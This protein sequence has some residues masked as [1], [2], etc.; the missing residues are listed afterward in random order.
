MYEVF[1]YTVNED[2][3]TLSYELKDKFLE[4]FRSND[5]IDEHLED[6]TGITA[7]DAEIKQAAYDLV[8]ACQTSTTYTIDDLVADLVEYI[9]ENE[10]A[11][12]YEIGYDED[13][14]KVVVN[15]T[16][17]S[18][19]T[20]FLDSSSFTSSLET[21]QVSNLQHGYYLMLDADV[22]DGETTNLVTAG[23]LYTIPR[24]T[25][26]T[27]NSSLTVAN[28]V[29]IDVKGSQ[30]TI[31]KEVWHNDVID[32]MNSDYSPTYGTT[33]SW[34]VISDYQIG[35]TVDYR[36][37][38]TL[39]SDVTGYDEYIYMI[40]DTLP[41][42]IT[43]DA[44]SVKVYKDAGLTSNSEITALSS[45]VKYSLNS[46]TFTLEITDLATNLDAYPSTIYIYYT[47][48]VTSD[49]PVYEDA[50]TNTVY[51]DFSSNPY[52]DS[53]G[54]VDSSVDTYTFELN[55]LKTRGD[56][57]SGLAN[58]VFVLSEK[59][60][61]ESAE[62]SYKDIPLALD[63][64]GYYYPVLNG[65][66]ELVSDEEGGYSTSTGYVVTGDTGEFKIKGLDDAT[67]YRLTEYAAPDGYNIA[68]P[69]DFE[70]SMAYSDGKEGSPDVLTVNE[71]SSV[72]VTNNIPAVTIINTSSQLL[73]ETGGM[74]TTVFMIVGGVMMLGALVLLVVKKRKVYEIEL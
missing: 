31:N 69:V 49:M 5:Y 54:Q 56:G 4:F 62:V 15:T 74:G 21:I 27:E 65:S 70:I 50:A 40:T 6:E 12:D 2:K 9:N 14:E 43:L 67:S 52:D 29:T 30:P 58:A 8:L 19:K 41:T 37:T 48:T 51:L 7:T 47:G 55:V 20:A 36:V 11:T 73:P 22:F 61:S 16:N 53:T 18:L 23:A 38:A 17:T 72:T 42:G 63:D 25:I 60:V 13:A 33:G 26:S 35:D 28:T 68:S 66:F 32:D 57:V 45:A 59:V 10:T 46:N 24:V 3:D 1:E 64:D 71:G 44:N 34:D 39:P